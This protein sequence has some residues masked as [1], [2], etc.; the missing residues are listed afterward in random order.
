MDVMG[1]GPPFLDPGSR[2]PVSMPVTRNSLILCDVQLNCSS[3]PYSGGTR[4]VNKLNCVYF[5]SLQHGEIL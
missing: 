5:Q 4:F 1:E 3:K 2:G